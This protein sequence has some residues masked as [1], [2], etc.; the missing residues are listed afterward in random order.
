MN[1]VLTQGLCLQLC[2]VSER[3]GGGPKAVEAATA[4]HDTLMAL[5]TDASH[6]MLPESDTVANELHEEDEQAKHKAPLG[7]LQK[8]H[9][10]GILS[11]TNCMLYVHCL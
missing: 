4:A 6:G 1:Q 11:M 7:K 10:P 8:G 3:E 2:Y 5:G 9:N